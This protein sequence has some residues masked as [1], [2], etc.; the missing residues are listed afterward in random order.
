MKRTEYVIG[1]D[2]GGTKTA[3][4]LAS[5]SGSVVAE[6]TGGA[7]NFQVIGVEEAARVLHEVITA[8]C[9]K[10]GCSLS[11]VGAVVA[12]LGGAG[13][14]ADQQRMREAVRQRL[15][16]KGQTVPAIL[17]ESDARIALEGAFKGAA[18]IILISGTGSIA[19]G[20]GYD[21]TVHRVGGWGRILGDEGSGYFL[22]REG[23]NVV[24]RSLDGRI[25]KTIL[26]KLVAEKF[27]LADQERI[28]AAVYRE[29]FDIA[30]VA[31][32]VIQ[33]AAEHDPDCERIL[34]RA[35]FEL[36]EHVRA[37]TLKIEAS[38]RGHARQKLPLAF[39][40]SVITADSIFK[41]ILY[42]K[43]TFSLPQI[44][45][46]TPAS[47][48]AFGAVLMAQRLAEAP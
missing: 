26:A 6:A 44:S 46:V 35:T 22:G 28:I 20:K 43:I 10:A 30:S 1:M 37:L 9:G 11:Q 27:G 38:A 5:R 48:P 18:G 40:G 13:R 42:H 41:K 32:L 36:T 24:T 25:R 47:P 7:S 19:F 33:A 21:G 23:L 12:G 39:I 34:N 4:M 8:C 14:E 45:I 2:G 29:N 3:A 31:P 16:K 17:I 15:A